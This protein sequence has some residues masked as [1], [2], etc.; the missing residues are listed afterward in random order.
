M[1]YKLYLA[2]ALDPDGTR[3]DLGIVLSY[4]TTNLTVTVDTAATAAHAAATPTLVQMGA[5]YADN[6]EIQGNATVT[7][8]THNIGTSGLD[9][10]VELKCIWNNTHPTNAVRPRV[11]VEYLY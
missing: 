6:V 4:D 11:Y 2:S 1:D 10:G 9:S 8:G 7:M 5:I 3:E